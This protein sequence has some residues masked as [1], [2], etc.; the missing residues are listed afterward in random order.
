MERVLKACFKS[1]VLLFCLFGATD[2]SLATTVIRP[3]DDDMAIGARAIIRGKVLSIESRFDEQQS[4]I[5][6]YITLRVQEVIKGEITERKIVIKELGGEAG[7]RISVIYGNPQFNRGEKVLLYLDTWKDGSLRTYQMFLGKFSIIKDKAT[8]HEIVFRDMSDENITVLPSAEGAAHYTSTDRM[9]LSAYTKMVREKVAANEE[10]SRRFEATYYGGVSVLSRPHEYDGATSS[11]EVS[12]QFTFL[13]N[14]RWFE[15]DSG[16]PVTYTVNPTPSSVPGFPPLS[17]PAADVAA[18]AN[19]WS[20]VPGCALSVSFAGSLNQCYTVTGTPGINVVSNN[21]D[22]RNSPSVSCAGILAWGGWSGGTFETRIIGGISFRRITQGFISFNPYA[23]C[24]FSNHC[25]VQEITTHELGHALGLGHSADSTATMAAFAHFDGRCASIRQDDSNGIVFIYPGSG[26]G[27][28]SGPLS[29]VTSTM[30]SGTVG[31]AYS[32]TMAASGGTPP[33]S[34]SLV[35]GSGN[36]PPGLSLSSGG[37]VS[38]SPTT[39]GTYNFTARVTD[40]VLVSAEKAL[41]IA[42]SAAGT[43]YDS[44]FLSQT[45]SSTLTPGQLFTANLVWLNTGT[46]DWDGP[47]GALRLISQNPFNNTAWGGN[48]VL[49]SPFFVSPGQQ[50]NVTFQA[51]APTTPGTYNFQWQL[52][53]DA[54][55]LF[56][57]MSTNFVI[58]VGSG[59]GGGGGGTNGA[60]FVSQSVP[61]SMTAGQTASVSVTMSNTGTTTWS[62][63]TYLL[64]SIN[65]AGN[66]TWG[67]SQA[68][69]ASSV[70]PG[71]N[72]TFNFNV[73]APAS[74][75]TYNFQWQMMQSGVGSFGTPSTNLAVNVTS[76]GGTNDATFSTQS[77]PSS[78]TAGQ[79]VSVSVTMTNNGT[80][81]WSAGTYCLQ[82]Q[83]PQS[84]STWGLSRINVPSPVAPGSSATFTF[85][86]TAPAT[87]GTYNFQWRMAQDGVGTFGGFSSNVAVVVSASSVQPLVITTTSLPLGARGLPYSAQVSATGGEPAYSWSLSAGSLPSGVTLNAS[88]G[89]ISGTPS[90]SGTF[91]FTVMVRDQGGR[92]ATRSFKVLF[93]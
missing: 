25:N 50:L 21:C 24:S 88:T 62:P 89:L 44:Q 27:G 64:G 66:S 28:S 22:G 56:G 73:T 40:T 12:P 87:A 45:V 34:W 39:A 15:P 29:I 19:A 20:V 61:S 72:A 92:S 91:N 85:S 55:S 86:A 81:T 79:S 33:Y 17:V 4:R 38:G 84:N 9:E 76:G 16:Q 83:N 49:L 82:S 43:S 8:G 26:G 77:V 47:S 23:V 69:L 48:T 74:A 52:A 71:S 63:G 41:S 67:L 7:G 36:L 6:T 78:M 46:Q 30:P 37:L 5:Y 57:Q 10:R 58:T 14:A 2:S 11:G 65:P 80:N 51:I 35:S 75:G 60:G 18:A 93:R 68:G 31:S 13:G 59:G 42:V 3:S 1:L 32:Q 90:I 53:R 70:P 54:S